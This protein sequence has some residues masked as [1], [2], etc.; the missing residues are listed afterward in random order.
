MPS[1]TA[2]QPIPIRLSCENCKSPNGD[3]W[4][5]TPDGVYTE[6]GRQLRGTLQNLQSSAQCPLCSKINKI[7][8]YRFNQ[9]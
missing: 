6:P 3:F 4:S 8:W 9:P 5:I 2:G 1:P 7:Y